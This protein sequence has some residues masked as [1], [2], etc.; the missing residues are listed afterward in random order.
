[1]KA[2]YDP[3]IKYSNVKRLGYLKKR[4]KRAVP[5]L[6]CKAAYV[7]EVLTTGGN[8]GRFLVFPRSRSHSSICFGIRRRFDYSA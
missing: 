1:M 2:K 7:L 6:L 4:G 3:S 5:P 8:L